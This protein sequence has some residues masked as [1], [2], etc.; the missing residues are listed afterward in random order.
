MKDEILERYEVRKSNKEKSEFI[1][2]I[3]ERL[4]QY[5]YNVTIDTKGKGMF[6]SRNIIVGDIN[7]AKYIFTAHYDTCALSP[8]P[9]LMAPLS[10]T[11]YALTQL[12]LVVFLIAL[13]FI[14]SFITSL[15]LGLFNVN[16]ITSLIISEV[17]SLGSLYLLIYQMMFGYRNPHTANDNTS[18]VI[19]LT[20]LLEKLP[21]NRRDEVC[22][23]YFDNEEKGL[24][25][26]SF[27][28]K[29][30]K[31]IVED[32][33]LFNIDCLGDGD[34]IAFL[35]SKNAYD[36]PS[37]QEI[38][39]YFNSTERLTFIN[40]SVPKLLF[41]SDQMH[42]KKGIGICALRNHK[43][44]AYVPNLH[45]PKDTICKQENIDFVVDG[46]VNFLLT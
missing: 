19:T 28:N 30:Y 31:G 15:I 41:P 45:T 43:W 2:Y 36:N 14:I 29:K 11:S 27:F 3:T 38:I 4:N 39:T 25:G 13:V 12:L 40:K 18:G 20:H 22:V 6:Q 44:I 7:K 10:I 8:L 42:F 35:P 24:L 21:E 9:N 37:Y 32:K 16:Y 17:I 5:G 33:L 34:L 23:V 26:S 46:F 1:D